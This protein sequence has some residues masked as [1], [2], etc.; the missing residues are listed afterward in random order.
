M[1]LYSPTAYSPDRLAELKAI[2]QQI[3]SLSLN[4][5]PVK[6]ADLKAVRQFENLQK[7]DLNF[8]DI[9]GAGLGELTVLKQ[10]KNLA[11]SGTKVNY[12]DLRRQ[13]GQFKNLKTVSVWETTLTPAEI[14][15]IARAFPNVKFI[16]G[17]DGNRSEPITLNPPQVDNAS[18][19][20]NQSVAVQLKH[21]VKGVQIRYT[22]VPPGPT[23]GW[24]YVKTTWR[25]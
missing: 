17:F 24:G 3:V 15:Q 9:T 8:T 2:R 10:L 22:T 19:I 7:L 12:A 5:L 13:M 18:T 23:T 25:S 20:F 1:N 4:K 21:P 14:A 16:G 11:L 6:D